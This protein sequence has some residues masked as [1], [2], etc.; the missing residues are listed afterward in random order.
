MR[1]LKAGSR[2]LFSRIWQVLANAVAVLVIAK[3][4]GPEGQGYFSLTVALS[5][6]L[7]AAL[8]GG[9]GLAAVPPL[10][11]RQVP[12][13]R[14]LTAQ[15]LWALA[16]TLVMG[17]LALQV[18]G[19]ATAEFM[20]R[21]LGWNP[22]M[23]WLAA[24]A[25]L[26]L[27]S[28]DIFAYDLLA[29]GRLVVGAAVNGYRALFYLAIIGLLALTGQL[30]LERAVAAFAVSQAAGAIAMLVIL[31]RETRNPRYGEQSPPSDPLADPAADAPL[32]RDEDFH[33]DSSSLGG[34]IAFNLRRG[35][36]GQLSAVAY[37]LL[38]RL[39]QGLLAHFRGAAE[40]GIYS[41]AVYMGEMLWLLPGALTPILVHTSAT[42][43]SDPERDATAWQAVRLGILITFAAA[44]PLYL[45]AK[46]MLAFLAG[47]QYQASGAALRA[48]LPG[49]VAFAP[50]A[51]LAGDFI[52]RG[53]PH[54]NTQ[55]STLTVVINVIAGWILIPRQGAIGAAYASSIAY[56]CGS[57]LMVFRFRQ[58][59]GLFILGRGRRP[60]AAPAD[61]SD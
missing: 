6:L 32:P 3:T 41:L 61:A 14:M 13:V 60:G 48:L 16:M 51:V 21:Y 5:M 50:G 38:L 42:R 34:L 9:M 43:A 33:L 4:L 52:G 49:I 40:V 31:I 1:L 55:A 46:P 19:G 45:L 35:W 7:G 29:R 11:Q 8:G 15:L 53:K 12:I 54:W 24:L 23:A 28:F 30:T 39:D 2:I 27:L 44:V 58:A 17:V 22:S 36:I 18:Q 47:G 57:A 26:G 20:A 56:F 37:F 10:R 59:T 25:G